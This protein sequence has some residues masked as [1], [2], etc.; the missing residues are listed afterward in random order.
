MAFMRTN[1]QYVVWPVAAVIGAVGYGIEGYVGRRETPTRDDSIQ[2]GRLERKLGHMNPDE[3]TNV[4]TLKS[5]QGIP[6]TV[7]NRNDITRLQQKGDA[8]Q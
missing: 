8:S 4:P 6:R 5:K 7:L 3:A 1:A 2:D